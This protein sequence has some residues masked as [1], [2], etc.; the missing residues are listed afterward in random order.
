MKFLGTDILAKLVP[1]TRIQNVETL[2][3]KGTH[4]EI[5]DAGR[6]EGYYK[7]PAN[8]WEKTKGIGMVAHKGEEHKVAAHWYQ[9]KDKYGINKEEPKIKLQPTGVTWIE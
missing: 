2:S 6:L 4:S 5:R 8:M 3:G 1:G 7:V 9:Y